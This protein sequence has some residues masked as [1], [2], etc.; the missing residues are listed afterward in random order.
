LNTSSV[1]TSTGTDQLYTCVITDN[2]GCTLSQDVQVAV[3]TMDPSD[4]TAQASPAVLCVGNSSLLSAVY[5]GS[6]PSVVLEWQHCA[7][8]PVLTPVTPNATTTY[9]VTATNYCGQTIDAGVTVVVNLP[10]N[11]IL[12]PNSGELCPD[13]YLQFLNIGSNNSGWDYLWTFGDGE[14]STLPSP[15]H[16]YDNAGTY[17]VSLTV[18]DNNGC[19]TSVVNGATILVNPQADA[20]FTASSTQESILNPVFSFTNS[21]M[22]ADSYIW[23]FGD[24]SSATSTNATHTY[25]TFGFFDVQLYA[26][27]VHDCPDSTTLRIE[28]EPSFDIYVP[29]AFT[30]DGDHYNQLFMVQGYGLLEEGFSMEIYDR[31]GEVIYA[32]TDIHEGWDGTYRSEKVVQDGVYTWVVYFKDLTNKSHRIDG[33]VSILR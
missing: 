20:Q 6:D 14:S 26:N 15:A 8:C 21:S 30:P 18:T 7:T 9:T 4:L 33:H 13:E 22:N 1:Q 28:V 5:S 10:P 31:W 19:S 3:E 32:S 29:N 17:N 2:N 12:T 11:V 24:G 16:S 23:T 25:E 27:N